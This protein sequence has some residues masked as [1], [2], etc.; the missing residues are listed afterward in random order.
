MLEPECINVC[1]QVKGKPAD[2]ICEALDKQWLIKVSHAKWKGEEVI[3]LMTVNA[4]MTKKDIDNF[5]KHVKN[6][7]LRT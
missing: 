6:V 7:D 3:R 2:K 4:D 1:F 5:F